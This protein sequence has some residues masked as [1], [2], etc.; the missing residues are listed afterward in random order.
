MVAV[1]RRSEDDDQEMR[2]EIK[3]SNGN[4]QVIQRR[5]QIQRQMASQ[6]INSEVP[7]ADFIATN[8]TELAIAVSYN[9]ER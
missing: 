6:R 3:E 7:K 9:P 8:P 1:R 4:P 2:E 5:K